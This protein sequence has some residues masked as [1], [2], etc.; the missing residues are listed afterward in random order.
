MNKKI[1][2]LAPAGD[3]EKL[4]IAYLYGAD[5]CFIGG[6]DY[7]LRARASNFTLEDIKEGADFAHNLGKKLYITTNIIPHNENYDGLVKYLKSLEKANVDG[8]IVASPLIAKTAKKHTNLEI[9]ISTQQSILNNYHLKYWEDLGAT[10]AVLGRELSVNQIKDIKSKTNLEIEVFIH[11]GMC[12]S[13]SGR[14]T[15]SN[16]FT[17]RDANRGGCAHSCRWNYNIYDQDKKISTEIPFSMGSTDLQA[18]KEV[19]S[20]IAA[21]VDSLKIEGRMK[22]LHYIATVVSV[23]RKLIDEFLLT[24]HVKDISIYEDEIAKAESRPTNTGFLNVDN[25]S[26]IQLYDHRP[27]KPSQLFVG[28]VLGNENNFTQ[29][30]QR[31][32][33]Q[34]GDEL[35]LFGPNKKLKRFIVK[36]MFDEDFNELVVARHPQQKIYIKIPYETSEYDILRKVNEET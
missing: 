16:T 31:N 25:I 18:I 1:E 15:L 20:L 14:C 9:H 23:Y 11:G 33:F 12:S 8:I 17:L 13:Y 3:L 21:G 2:L 5:A 28:L 30:E 32:H 35:E 36:E 6:I 4:K 29:I 19:P 34:V 26:E 10:R 24:N 22:S 7:S 27:L